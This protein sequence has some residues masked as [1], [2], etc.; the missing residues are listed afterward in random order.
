MCCRTFLLTLPPTHTQVM[1]ALLSACHRLSGVF[2]NYEHDASL[3]TSRIPGHVF[4]NLQLSCCLLVTLHS[5]LQRNSS[6]KKWFKL[7]CLR[8][9]PGLL[10]SNILTGSCINMT[11]CLLLFGGLSIKMCLSNSVHFYR[12]LATY[13]Q[14]YPIAF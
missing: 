12:N 3:D 6:K 2:H 4:L 5:P 11:F 13:K 9:K 8:L 14:N 7:M 10:Q 1:R